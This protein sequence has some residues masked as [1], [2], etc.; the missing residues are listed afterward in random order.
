MGRGCYSEVIFLII[1]NIGVS[2]GGKDCVDFI[3]RFRTG[4]VYF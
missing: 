2:R 3:V 4:F 1:E